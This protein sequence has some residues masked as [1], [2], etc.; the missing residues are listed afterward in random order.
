MAQS[1]T[2]AMRLLDKAKAAYTVHEY[3]TQDGA[4]DGVSVAHKLGQNPQQVFKTLVTKAASG[5]HYVFVIPVEG[6]LDLKK[7]AR[8]VGE[9]SVAMLPVAD[10][11][12]VTGYVRGGC[13][14][15]GM[16]KQLGTVIH[17]SAVEQHTIVVS[18]GRIGAQIELEPQRLAELCG[19][20][21]EDIVHQA[22][23]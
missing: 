3:S 23:Q 2:N 10:L 5:Q 9:K 11:L 14:P 21:F 16:K 8:T 17:Q 6:E 12:K 15:L 22:G 1:K 13:S 7:A 19:A 4:I 18:G 20:R